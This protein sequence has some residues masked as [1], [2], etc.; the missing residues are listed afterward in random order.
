MSDAYKLDSHKMIYHPRRTADVLEAK[1]K[2][3]KGCHIYPIY[4]ELSPIGACNHRCLFCAVDYVGYHPDRL[5]LDIMRQRFPEMAR[6]GVKSVNFAGEGEPMLHKAIAPMIHAAKTGGLDTSLTTNAS[7]LPHDFI[8]LALPCLSWLK[9][10]INAGTAPT[11]A[12]IHR[13]K[14]GDFAKVTEH[15]QAMVAAKRTHHLTCVLGAQALLLPDN[16]HEMETLAHLCRNIGMDY[17][18]VKPYSQHLSSGNWRYETIDYSQFLDLGERLRRLSTPTFSLVFREHTMKK[19]LDTTN[20]YDRCYATPFLWAHIMATGVVSGCSAYLMD[21]RFE[22]GNIHH[23]TFEEIWQG[24]KRQEGMRFVSE[25]LDIKECR[26]N[27]RMDEV[28][29]YL[30]AIATQSPPHINFI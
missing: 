12:A 19:T 20:R 29:R 16:A 7:I 25:Q 8:D 9:V 2:W 11:Y 27:C 1:G 24:A 21:Q 4:V 28:N 10:S 5:D 6:L 22:Y 30:H 23:N 26:L 14:E 18:V 15:M 3:D 13:T 17:L